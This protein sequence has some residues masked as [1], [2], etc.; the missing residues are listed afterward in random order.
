MVTT[1]YVIQD[2]AKVPIGEDVKLVLD[3]IER[4]LF[5]D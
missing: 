3:N 2:T 4:V 1:N 5:A